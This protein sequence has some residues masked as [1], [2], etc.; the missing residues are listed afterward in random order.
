MYPIGLKVT[1]QH[2]FSDTASDTVVVANVAPT[3]SIGDNGPMAE[4]TA[5][6][7]SGVV[8]DAGWLETPL[9]ATIDWGDGAAQAPPGAVEEACG[10]SRRSRTPSSTSTAT[11]ASSR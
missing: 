7:V 3:V 8:S 11:T 5:V 10:R 1:N 9:T 6:T 4:N 2:G